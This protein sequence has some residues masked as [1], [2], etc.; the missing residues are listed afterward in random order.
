MRVRRGASLLRSNP[1]IRSNASSSRLHPRNDLLPERMDCQ[2]TKHYTRDE[3]RALL[4]QIR[5]WL[6]HL[7]KLRDRIHDCD[8]RIAELLSTR[9]DIGGELVNHWLRTVVEMK[10]VAGEFEKREI[11]IK[12]L[13]RGLIDFPAFLGD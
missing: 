1:T 2:F 8:K 13:D 10:G 12:D 3:A 9:G 7:V 5:D 11:Q 6:D 4:P